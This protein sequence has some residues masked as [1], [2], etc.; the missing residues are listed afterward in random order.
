MASA[1]GD[2]LIVNPKEEIEALQEV[3]AQFAREWWKALMGN[4]CALVEDAAI[5]AEHDSPGRAQALLVLAME[6]LAKARW[7]YQ[8][9][10]WEW[11]A[12]I[13]LYGQESREP[14][15]VVVPYQLST[16]RLPHAEKLA[17]AEQYAS[18]LGG[19]WHTD[20]RSEYY[21][22]ADLASFEAAAKRRNL[23]KQAGFYVDREGDHL[24]SPLAIPA[25]D[26]GEF[27]IRA[28]QCVEMHLIEDHTRQQDASDPTL[29]DSVQDLHWVILPFAHPADF[30]AFVAR[31]SGQT[32]HR[33]DDGTLPH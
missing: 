13:G 3:A 8:A 23:D 33:G 11:S 31:M 32:G 15:D 16:R 19:F 5:L 6:E 12:P 24:L 14:R 29:I 10:E 26:V 1:F 2:N 7:I 20:R 4:A 30:A 21:F 28:A 9:A 27:L 25:G 17:A 22:P 18:G